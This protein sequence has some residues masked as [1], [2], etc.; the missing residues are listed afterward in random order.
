LR[1]KLAVIGAGTAGLIA[2]KRAAELGIDTTVY[3]QKQGKGAKINASGIVSLS[4][5]NALG[6]DYGGAITNRLSGADIHAGG[7]VLSVR[8]RGIIANVLDRMQLNEM[9]HDEAEASGVK[10]NMGRRVGGAEIGEIA[11]DSVVIGADGAVSSVARHFSMGHIR[12]HVLTYKQEFNVDIKDPEKVDL[13]FDNKLTQGLFGWTCPNSMDILEVGIGVDSGFSNS[14]KAMSAFLKKREIVEMIDGGKSIGGGASMIPMS[15]RDRISDNRG[16]MLVGDAAG[17]VKATTGGGI[18]FGGHGG[19]LAA[20]IAAEHLANGTTIYDYS[21]RY[22]A[23]YG[24]DL[25]LHSM[26]NEF[27]SRISADSLGRI[28][29]A[30][31]FFGAENFLHKYGDMDRPSLMVKRFFLRALSD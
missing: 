28:I 17:Q 5:L 20:E 24:R 26:I 22:M 25:H 6:I 18:V 31:K 3:E 14:A 8:A 27:Y 4:G 7:R 23:R 10:I 15:L 16:A 30:A 12:R 1:K 21:R 9:C 13:F 2:A 11:R 19:R 29:T